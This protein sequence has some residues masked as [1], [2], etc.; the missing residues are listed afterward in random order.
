MTQHFVHSILW[1]EN[2]S[3]DIL[4]LSISYWD[5]GQWH[6]N[7][8]FVVYKVECMVFIYLFLFG[9]LQPTQCA[10]Y[11]FIRD[12]S[13]GIHISIGISWCKL[14]NRASSHTQY[15]W[16]FNG[17]LLRWCWPF[18]PWR[19]HIWMAFFNDQMVAPWTKKREEI[20]SCVLFFIPFYK[21]THFFR[22][23]WKEQITEK[24]ER[25]IKKKCHVAFETL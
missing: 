11:N 5:D 14:S 6:F 19:K 2:S 21:D 9:S 22:M 1:K 16:I 3:T 12:K 7:K 13:V 4:L 20:L 15:S 23:N 18:I 17:L 8:Y 24:K 25:I 10:P